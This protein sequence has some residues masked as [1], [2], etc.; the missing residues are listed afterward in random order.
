MFVIF[1]VIITEFKNKSK[2][3]MIRS[4]IRKTHRETETMKLS[5]KKDLKS[6]K[7]M[8]GIL[9]RNYN[10]ILRKQNYINIYRH[11]LTYTNKT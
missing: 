7:Q 5:I 8:R 1:F 3:Q 4:A 11:I 10:G 6:L 2:L 9:I